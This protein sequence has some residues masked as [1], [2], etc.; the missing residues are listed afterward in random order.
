MMEHDGISVQQN[1]SS[2][3]VHIDNNSIGY[4]LTNDDEVV[5]WGKFNS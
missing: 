5:A 3:A 2:L 4:D 1:G